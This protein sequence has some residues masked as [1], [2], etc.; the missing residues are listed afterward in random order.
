MVKRIALVLAGAFLLFTLWYYFKNPLTTKATI[1]GHVFYVEVAATPK[2]REQG[3]SGRQ[4]LAQNEGML[5]VYQDQALHGFWMRGMNF[6]LDFIWIRDKTVVQLNK[7][8]PS[9]LQG[10]SLEVLEPSVPVD[11]VLEVNAGTIDRLGI[12]PGDTIEIN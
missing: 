3:L 1:A 8:V 6:P 5:F 2:A 11:M 9:P 10:G 4:S 12:V 7:N